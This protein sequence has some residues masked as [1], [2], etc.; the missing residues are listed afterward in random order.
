MVTI[1][2]YDRFWAVFH[3]GELLA[4]VVYKKGALAIKALIEQI[5]GQREDMGFK[6]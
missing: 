2:R 5:G 4:V 3:E 6:V 1:E